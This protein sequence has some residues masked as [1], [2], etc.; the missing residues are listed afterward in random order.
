MAEFLG[1]EWTEIGDDYLKLSMPVNEHKP[2]LWNFAWRR[3]LCAC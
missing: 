1:M 3:F 2:T